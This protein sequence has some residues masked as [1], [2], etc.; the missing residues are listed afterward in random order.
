[1][2]QQLK[3]LNAAASIAKRATLRA[4]IS[5]VAAE[6]AVAKWTSET[7]QNLEQ[8]RFIDIQRIHSMLAARQKKAR[9][10]W[11]S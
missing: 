4:L 5:A 10:W 11:E 1:M 6:Q 9:K 2:G 8:D 3:Q 7:A